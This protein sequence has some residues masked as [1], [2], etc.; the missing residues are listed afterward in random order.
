MAAGDPDYEFGR[1]IAGELSPTGEVLLLDLLLRFLKDPNVVDPTNNAA[2]RGLRP[3]VIARKVSQCSKN[4]RGAAARTIFTSLIR[5]S[6][7]RQVRSAITA[8]MQILES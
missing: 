3:S 2:E 8:L 6:E 1:L 5:T 7:K 4:W